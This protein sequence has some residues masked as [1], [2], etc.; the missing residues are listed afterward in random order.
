MNFNPLTARVLL[1]EACFKGEKFRVKEISS[2][3]SRNSLSLGHGGL[4]IWIL[5]M[6]LC[7]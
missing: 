5:A 6:D 1:A 7:L 2:S 4:V 3:G